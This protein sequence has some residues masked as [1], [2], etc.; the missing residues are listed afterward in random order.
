MRWGR[1]LGAF[2]RRWYIGIVGLL[3]TAGLGFAAWQLSPPTYTA[4]G[5]QLLLP[6]ESQVEQGTRN[7]LLE[8]GTLDGP[9]AL[10]IAHL[11]GQSAR[12]EIERVAPDAEFTV[13]PDPALRG[14]TIMVTL[15]ENT[16]EGALST[17]EL[18]L[19]DVPEI[20]ARMQADLDVPPEARV[21]SMRLA[22]DAEST[23]EYSDTLRVV[24]LAVGVGL[25]LSVVAI[26]SI[27]VLIRRRATRGQPPRPRGGRTGG[28]RNEETTPQP[29]DDAAELPGDRSAADDATDPA[30]SAPDSV[31]IPIADRLG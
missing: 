10:V 2:G 17:L 7:P 9:G 16:A 29:A 20:L 8:L 31:S 3:V 11:N 1:T 18:V 5:T 24:V 14:P 15:S 25:A 13:E 19:D 4:Q 30:S 28:E 23:P 27:D 26:V 12:A 22:I 21:S 6:P